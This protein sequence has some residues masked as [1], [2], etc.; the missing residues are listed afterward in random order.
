MKRKHLKDL[1]Q[2]AKKI[3]AFKHSNPS[4]QHI[5]FHL[6]RASVTSLNETYS[7]V[8]DIQ[9][10]CLVPLN[11]A[12][13]VSRRKG[14]EDEIQIQENTLVDGTKKTKFEPGILEDYPTYNLP[15]CET[16]AIVELDP[17]HTTIK[18][19]GAHVATGTTRPILNGIYLGPEGA[20]ATQGKTMMWNPHLILSRECIVEYTP[21][22]DTLKQ[23]RF[24]SIVEIKCG[25]SGSNNEVH[26]MSSN[27]T[28]YST[29]LIEGTYPA[30]KQ[31]I[32]S[33]SSDF[34]QFDLSLYKE[35]L[36]LLCKEAGS[37]PIEIANNKVSNGE[38]EIELNI[39]AHVYV[40]KGYL[41]KALNCGF[42]LVSFPPEETRRPLIL[43]RDEDETM[44]LIMPFHKSQIGS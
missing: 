29:V 20:V 18:E 24:D 2:A 31:V 8:T 28:W 35:D 19:L 5:L 13:K 10:H 43:H 23:R 16:I 34:R 27:G 14:P 12:D 9:S 22:L 17:F 4:L 39:N 38:T 41:E 11:L 15:N 3:G 21:F 7:V 42:T 44:V 37:A 33:D 36:L 25:E 30:F 1:C 6:G 26:L 40:H 32:P